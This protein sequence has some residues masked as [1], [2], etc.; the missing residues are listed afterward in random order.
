VDI[1]GA[2]GEQ[3]RA[4]AQ[5]VCSPEATLR[6]AMFFLDPVAVVPDRIIALALAE[7]YS[8]TSVPSSKG[9]ALAAQVLAEFQ[10]KQTSE[11]PCSSTMENT[12]AESAARSEAEDE[13]EAPPAL[14]SENATGSVTAVPAD[15]G[16]GHSMQISE[17][18]SLDMGNV[19]D[20][21]NEGP[22]ETENERGMKTSEDPCSLITLDVAEAAPAEAEEGQDVQTSEAP[23]PLA[24]LN[25]ADAS[26]SVQ[27]EAEDED[28]GT[29]EAHF[30]LITVDTAAAPAAPAASAEIEDDQAMQ[31]AVQISEAPPVL[32][33]EN[34]AD[35]ELAAVKTEEEQGMQI[36]ETP[37]LTAPAPATPG[38]QDAQR[39]Q[40]SEVTPLTIL[41]VAGAALAARTEAV[42]EPEL[43]SSRLAKLF[44][45]AQ[46]GK[47]ASHLVRSLQGK[48]AP[49]KETM[50]RAVAMALLPRKLPPA[51]APMQRSAAKVM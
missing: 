48:L 24:A 39:M 51:V 12:S 18:P 27:T 8:L 25:V 7:A 43:A 32:T 41:D 11:A 40:T 31:R 6:A 35:T 14:T 37:A 19:A 36:S 49:A 21:S 46:S 3:L 38:L 20:A 1:S 34:K 22:V 2:I 23:P 15:T 26:T 42:D 47:E 17:E 4:I 5:S 44:S 30:P 13:Q 16:D 29:S 28:M 33:T 9:E 45:S 50:Q 10:S